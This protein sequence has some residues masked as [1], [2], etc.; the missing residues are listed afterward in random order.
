[1]R[2]NLVLLGMMG[3]GK[4]TL[5]K[6]LAKNYKLGFVDIDSKIEEKTMMSINEIFEKK[7][8]KFFREEEE[9]IALNFL[10]KK[11]CI[12]ALG[13]GAFINAFIRKEIKDSCLSFWLDLD[14]NSLLLRLK[15]VKKRPLLDENKLKESINEIYSKRK[16][17]YNESNFRIKCNSMDKDEIIYKIIKLYENSRNQI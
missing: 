16:K 1:M 8:E 10:N 6:I 12:V 15:N 5:G 2:K 14:V 4:T 11:N 7:G 3:V 13:G 9:K 17:I